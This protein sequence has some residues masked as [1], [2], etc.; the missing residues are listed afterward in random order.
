VSPPHTHTQRR[1]PA[2]EH[3]GLL[4]PIIRGVVGDTL[5]VTFRNNLKEHNVSMHPHGVWYN[6]DSEGSP[7]ADGLKREF[8]WWSAGMLCCGCCAVCATSAC[9]HA[10]P[11]SPG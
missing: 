7:Y 10:A 5:K 3:M 11:A 1:A 9:L 6:K 4:G 2:F 8:W